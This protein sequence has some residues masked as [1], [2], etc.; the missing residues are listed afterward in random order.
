MTADF[1]AFA[2]SRDPMD[3]ERVGSR[4]TIA[5]RDIDLPPLVSRR[6]EIAPDHSFVPAGLYKSAV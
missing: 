1:F 3:Y 4:L 6:V 5:A 2:S